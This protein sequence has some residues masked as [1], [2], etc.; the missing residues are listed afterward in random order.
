MKKTY[1][2]KLNYKRLINFSIFQKKFD[3]TSINYL[4]E[5]LRIFMKN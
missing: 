4:F 5:Y 2:I 1:K 3:F